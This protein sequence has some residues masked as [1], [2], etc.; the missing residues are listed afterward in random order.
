MRLLILLL[1]FQDHPA[2]PYLGNP[3]D[4]PR[5]VSQK[6]IHE[7]N[8]KIGKDGKVI[9]PFIPEFKL[10]PSCSI[11]NKTNPKRAISTEDSS[12]TDHLTLRGQ[13][14]DVAHYSCHGLRKN[15]NLPAVQNAQGYWVCPKI[16]R[17]E[18]D[19]SVTPPVCHLKVERGDVD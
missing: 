2:R 6:L 17:Y 18:L 15:A 19:T 9:V 1:L 13:K 8:V 4:D 3:N 7:G 12:A 5:A 14:D 10:P 16:D 11:S